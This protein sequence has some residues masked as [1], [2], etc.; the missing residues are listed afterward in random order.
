M[1][2]S[3]FRNAIAEKSIRNSTFYILNSQF[4]C[5]GGGFTWTN[6]C[7]S[8][9]SSDGVFTYSCGEN[10]HCT[11]CAALG[12][13][14]YEGFTLP[15]SGGSCGCAAMD[16][17]DPLEPR[18]TEDDG[19]YSGGASVSFSHKAVIFEDGY[20]NKPG[21][22]VGR[23]STTSTLHCIVHGGPNGGHVRFEVE[24]AAR[25]ATLAGPPLP[26]EQD[27]SPG[28][29][30]EF[31][32]IYEGASPSAAEGDVV[33]IATYTENAEGAEPVSASNSLTCVKVELS[34]LNVSLD[35]YPN[36]HIRGIGE[37]VS[38]EWTPSVSGLSFQTHNGA[39]CT[40]SYS[41]RRDVTCPFQAVSGICEISVGGATY[42]LAV[43][44]L[45]PTG[46]EARNPRRLS[47]SVPVNSPGGAGFE[48]DLHIMPDT[49]SF[50]ALEFWERPNLAS[51]II[52]YFTNTAFQAVWYHDAVM[53]AGVWRR[54][55][56][57]NFWFKDT[58][59]MGDELI[60]P[61]YLGSLVWHIPIDWR[62][63]G[64]PTLIN[65]D[66]K[67]VDQTFEMSV[68]GRLTV[69]KYQHWAAREMSGET[70]KSEGMTE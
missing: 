14:S 18:E 60:T 27:V 31:S 34:S 45:E 40:D 25:L 20:W 32:V 24:N 48:M 70:F 43:Q 2:I 16:P 36:R 63:W 29:R 58:A 46:I 49:V 4:D 67:T 19:P 41:N 15:A 38:C 64:D 28:N 33:A 37:A 3:E 35:D 57:A 10:C 11:G 54:I 26:F 9:S 30:I 5:L 13:Y 68:S 8:I 22:W 51:T 56:S 23:H 7:C 62:K 47:Y 42:A 65:Q 53:G 61:V 17:D 44:V 50:Q 52:G 55:S 6:C 59:Q 69:S 66:F 39:V 1:I 12:T 21:E